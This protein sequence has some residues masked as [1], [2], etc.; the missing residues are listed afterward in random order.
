MVEV[1]SIRGAC[2]IFYL[3]L[4]NVSCEPENS[5][6]HKFTRSRSSDQARKCSFFGDSQSGMNMLFSKFL[7]SSKHD[8]LKSRG[9]HFLFE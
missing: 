7:C 2:M 5:Y 3:I 9:A 1:V 6:R 8:T 4:F